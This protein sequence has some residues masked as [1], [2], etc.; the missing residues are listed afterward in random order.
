MLTE[1]TIVR[2]LAAGLA[3][4]YEYCGSTFFTAQFSTTGVVYSPERAAYIYRDKEVWLSPHMCARVS[5]LPLLLGHP[6]D[7]LVDADSFAER[8]I[9]LVQIAFPKD[10]ALMCVCRVIGKL[11]MPAR[12]ETMPACLF[13]DEWPL[14]I[15]AG[16]RML[17]EPPPKYISHLSI[18]PVGDEPLGVTVVEP[19]NIRES[20][21][22]YENA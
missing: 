6:L 4:P 16:E 18:T 5:G 1:R 15:V 7:G 22:D 13:N 11:T 12:Y 3:S 10:D 21:Y 17:L 8:V 20:E 2:A 19:S 14:A 9:G